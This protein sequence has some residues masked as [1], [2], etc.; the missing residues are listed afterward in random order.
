MSLATALVVPPLAH[1]GHWIGQV[2]Y[3]L[4]LVV[5]GVLALWSKLRQRRRERAGE[6]PDGV[7]APVGRDPS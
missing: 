5:L 1:P 2:A 7:A 3:A 6:G 4:P